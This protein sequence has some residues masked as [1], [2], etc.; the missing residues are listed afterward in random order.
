MTTKA[1][2]AAYQRGYYAGQRSARSQT[3][4]TFMQQVF[5]AALQG[6]LVN[7]NWKTG[8]KRWTTVKEY[9]D[10]AWDFAEEAARQGNERGWL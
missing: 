4:S 7:A 3:Q 9:V 6:L 5:C 10:G 1:E 2:N 8:E